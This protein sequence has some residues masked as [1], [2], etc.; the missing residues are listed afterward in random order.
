LRDGEAG[1]FE[2]AIHQA[3]VS[4]FSGDAHLLFQAP[5]ALFF[6]EL[7]QRARKKY[8]VWREEYEKLKVLNVF[9]EELVCYWAEVEDDL[10]VVKAGLEM[11]D[12]SLGAG[13]RS[14]TGND[15]DFLV[16]NISLVREIEG[17]L[18]LSRREIELARKLPLNGLALKERMGLDLCFNSSID[19][20]W[21]H[22]QLLLAAGNLPDRDWILTTEFSVALAALK[23]MESTELVEKTLLRW[24]EQRNFSPTEQDLLAVRNRLLRL[25]KSMQH[26]TAPKSRRSRIIPID[27]D[28]TL[29]ER[30][31]TKGRF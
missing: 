4:G 10:R 19:Y 6:M 22:S 13:A 5:V 12:L 26:W 24:R 3:K 16:N 31:K 1:P 17:R 25:A 28:F 2:E 11:F 27:M 29:Y 20:S 30:P 18:K 21:G 14:Y 8:C 9:S 7:V 15:D 23:Q